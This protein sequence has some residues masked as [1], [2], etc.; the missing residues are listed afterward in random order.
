MA[1]LCRLTGD[2]DA[3]EDAMQVACVAALERWPVTGVPGNALGWLIGVAR[4]KARRPDAA[5][6]AAGALGPAAHRPGRAAQAP[7][8]ACGRSPALASSRQAGYEALEL[9]AG[10][11]RSTG[12]APAGAEAGAGVAVAAAQASPARVRRSDS[13]SASDSR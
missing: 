8:G 13:G 10:M 6:G 7:P 1:T 11:P 5:G 4:R 2:L 12:A 3:A 9:G